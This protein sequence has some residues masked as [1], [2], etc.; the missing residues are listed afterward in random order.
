MKS[1]KQQ[2]ITN[3][4]IFVIGSIG[5]GKS[6]FIDCLLD[7]IKDLHP[8]HIKEFID[9]DPEGEVKL[10]MNL[11]GEMSAFDFQKYIVDCY[12]NQFRNYHHKTLVVER[13][14]QESLLFASQ[15]LTR[16][17]YNKL[18]VY[19]K[20]MCQIYGVPLL[21]ECNVTTKENN[22]L[23][24][25]ENII[26]DIKPLINSFDDLVINL[27]VDEREQ[28]D[29]IRMRNRESDQKYLTDAGLR[30]LRKINGM[31]TQLRASKFGIYDRDEKTNVFV[32]KGIQ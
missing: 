30:Y 20:N 18:D 7:R 24:D 26:D 8:I 27:I 19:I 9:Y 10:N 15:F 5:V 3:N 6:T 25:M 29:R 2:K 28:V 17:D 31:Y 16:P 14:P 21:W 12:F 1:N 4:Y 23:E 32:F 22:Q 13:H 11:R